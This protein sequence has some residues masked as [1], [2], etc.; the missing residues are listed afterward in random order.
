VILLILVMSLTRRWVEGSR[1]HT[2]ASL[3]GLILTNDLNM[4]TNEIKAL[5]DPTT[6]KSAVSKDWVVGMLN[7]PVTGLNIADC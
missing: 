2:H 4:S 6:G 7:R 5:G 1:G 3:P